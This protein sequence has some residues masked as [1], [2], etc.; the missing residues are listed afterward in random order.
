V[1]VQGVGIPSQTYGSQFQLDVAFEANLHFARGSR[2]VSGAGELTDPIRRFG[3]NR[4]LE[5]ECP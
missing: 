1:A 4:R 3:G 2:V 5:L